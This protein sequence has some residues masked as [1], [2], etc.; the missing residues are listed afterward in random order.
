MSWRMFILALLSLLAG[1]QAMSEPREWTNSQGKQ[2][3]AEFGGL[4]AGNVTLIMP[5]GQRAT[6]T[7]ARL[8]AKDQGWVRVN[9]TKTT[10]S[11]MVPADAARILWNKR[12]M[13]N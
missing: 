13:P 6:V 11:S 9:A 4:K 7:Q 10:V 12:R 2:V 3:Q 8:L 5:G 1:S